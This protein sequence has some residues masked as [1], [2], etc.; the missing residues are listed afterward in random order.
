[1]IDSLVGRERGKFCRE[2]Y[3]FILVLCGGKEGFL[4]KIRM[5]AA[6]GDFMGRTNECA[7]IYI[8]FKRLKCQ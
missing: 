3:V 2:E 8:I 6:V 1:M 5:P 7:L 4:L